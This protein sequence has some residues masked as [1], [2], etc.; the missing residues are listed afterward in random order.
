MLTVVNMSI[1]IASIG[2]S[3]SSYST[4]TEDHL[5]GSGSGTPSIKIALRSSIACSAAISASS[6]SATCIL[7]SDSAAIFSET[8]FVEFALW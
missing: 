4:A 5:A 3:S 2:L 7:Y 6:L 8:L 1:L